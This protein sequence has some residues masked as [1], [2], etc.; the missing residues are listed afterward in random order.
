MRKVNTRSPGHE[1]KV[2]KEVGNLLE[3]G[4]RSQ[5]EEIY[6]HCPVLYEGLENVS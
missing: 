5:G 4:N 3:V 6:P 1:E 2:S